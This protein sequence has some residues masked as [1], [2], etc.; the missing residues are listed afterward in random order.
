MIKSKA[1]ASETISALVLVSKGL[2]ALGRDGRD[3]WLGGADASPPAGSGGINIL[4]KKLQGK[5]KLLARTAQ[6]GGGSFKHR[7]PRGEVGC[8]DAWMAELWIERWLET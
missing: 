4:D 7:K 8:C 6:D 5:Q 1:L 2:F 3:V